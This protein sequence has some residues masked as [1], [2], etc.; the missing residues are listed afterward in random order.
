MTTPTTRSLVPLRELRRGDRSFAG[1]KPANL[2]E[3]S[4]AGFTVPDGFVVIGDPE[5][6]EDSVRQAAQAFGD[7]LLAVRSSGVAEDL[8][9]ASFAGQYETILNVRGT[10]E[11]L[12]AIRRCRDS[13]QSAR[14]SR[15]QA[16]RT[17]MLDNQI[18]VLVQQMISPDASGVVFSANPVTGARDE[19]VV[20]AARG[21]GERIVSG[22]AVGD[23][24]LV[25]GAQ[26]ACRRS[27]ER[28]IDSEQ[29]LAIARLARQIE[30]HFSSPQDI[31]WAIAGGRVYVLQARPMTAL[32]DP[33]EWTPPTPGYWM[34]NLR[35][36]EWLPEP[37]TPLF[38]DWLLERIEAGYVLGM[39][40]T[41]GAALPFRHAAIN[42]WYFTAP[43]RF[44]PLALPRAIVQSRGKILPFLLNVIVHV[45]IRPEIAD[46]AALRRLTRV[47]REELLPRYQRLVHDGEGRVESAT[48]LE[49]ERLVDEVGIMAG[50]CLWSMAILGGSAWKME[51][52]L[53]KFLRQHLGTRL[54][55]S[56]QVLLRA[57]PGVDPEAPSHA[58][59]SVDWYRATAG[60]LRLARGAVSGDRRARLIAERKAA[61]AACR[62]S[63]AG[64]PAALSRF[65]T[66]LEVTQRFAAIREE[67]AHSFTLGWPLLRRCVLR[68]GGVL[69]AAGAI[70]QVED[71]FFLTRAEL[72]A[73]GQYQRVVN[74]RRVEWQRRRRLIAPL[75]IGQTPKIIES[76]LLGTV[77][78]VRTGDQPPP[79]AIVGHPASPG[80]ATGPVRIV[81]G[82]EDFGRFQSGDVLVAQATAP[83]WTPLFADAAAVVTDGGTLAAHASLV[84]RE[85][86]IPAV[87]GTGDATARLGDGQI[88]TV[89]GGAG[90][91]V[92]ADR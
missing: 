91:V 3:L 43:P 63:L 40:T 26:A 11:L 16:T 60:E 37:M 56:V 10:E 92:V 24:W 15:Y 51:G 1:T 50:E 52:C 13:A 67:Q 87:V 55:G 70:D 8:P 44:P 28:A 82:P 76:L 6:A 46:R 80:R 12:A 71:I 78:A 73:D 54:E 18:A 7:G 49:L 59:Q 83:A 2:G 64:D 85:Y 5:V 77:E 57:L 68:L 39:K 25:K 27:V 47:Y 45:G 53:A 23:E 22:E 61:E 32:P 84:A 36:G 41:T 35:L 21:L 62:S 48:P 31:E 74:L 89:D 9:D 69:Q 34:R 42:G 66:L 58:V 30:A 20:A 17:G 88:V 90:M 65:E 4:A 14:V 38:Q 19:I 29:A 86:G 81:R 79:G 33:V 75:T 72:H